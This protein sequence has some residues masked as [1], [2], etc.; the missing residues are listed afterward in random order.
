MES[1]VTETCCGGFVVL[2]TVACAHMLHQ[3]AFN[4]TVLK[5]LFCRN[6]SVGVG[7][8]SCEQKMII[9]CVTEII[10]IDANKLNNKNSG[11]EWVSNLS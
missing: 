8:I 7:A 3:Q 10:K 4:V 5:S 1:C 9:L 2:D 11:S 6:S